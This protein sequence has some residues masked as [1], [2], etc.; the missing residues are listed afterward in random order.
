M[1]QNEQEL[2]DF[3]TMSYKKGFIKTK[4]TKKNF[5]ELCINTLNDEDEAEREGH[6]M[7]NMPGAQPKR[8]TQKCEPTPTDPV[9]QCD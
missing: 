8:K 6:S 1:T 9:W 5:T 7:L 4:P 3:M 2:L